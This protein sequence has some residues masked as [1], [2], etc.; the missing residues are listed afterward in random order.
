MVTWPRIAFVILCA[1][2]LETSAEA[3]AQETVSVAVPDT[4]C[5][6]CRDFTDGATATGNVRTAYRP[7]V[8]YAGEAAQKGMA[9]QPADKELTV[10]V[11]ERP[12][13]A[14]SK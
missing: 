7:G 6:Y 13:G 3:F 12:S 2:S 8:G 10:Q 5:D 9:T 11:V 14:K 4:L 1:W